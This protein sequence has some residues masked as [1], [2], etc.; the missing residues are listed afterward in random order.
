ML[1]SQR[2]D[3]LVILQWIEIAQKTERGRSDSHMKRIWIVLILPKKIGIV[4]IV[5]SL[6]NVDWIVPQGMGIFLDKSRK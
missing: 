2:T 4:W 6:I 3:S 1:V 5:I